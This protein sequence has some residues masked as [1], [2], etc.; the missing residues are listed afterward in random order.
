M[1]A[2]NRDVD[3]KPGSTLALVLAIMPHGLSFIPSDLQVGPGTLLILVEEAH[4]SGSWFWVC[5]HEEG[6]EVEKLR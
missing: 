2:L 6:G 3:L 5:E 4:F 1:S